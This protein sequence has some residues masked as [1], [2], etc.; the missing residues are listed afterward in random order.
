MI[1]RD[2]K[3]ENVLL[4]DDGRVKVADF[5]LARAINAETQ[6]T[7][8]GGV[9]IGTVSYLSPEL[10][11]D[12]KADARSDVYAAGV[13]LYE[14]LTGRKPHEGDVADPGRLQARARGR[15][16]AVAAGARHPAVRRRAGRPRHRPRPRRCARPTRGCCCTR[17]AG[18]AHAL[19]H[20][21][22]RRPGADRRPDPDRA[23]CSALAR[24]H[25]LRRDEPTHG[26]PTILDPGAGRP[27]RRAGPATDDTSV[28]GA[29]PAPAA[30]PPAGRARGAP[31]RRP[32]APLAARAGAAGRWCCCS[33]SRAGV[34]GWWFGVGRYTTTPGVHQPDRGRGA[35]AKVAG[36]RAGV[37]RSADRAYS[38]TVPT[39]SVVS[40]DPARRRATSLRDGTVGAVVSRGP[41]RHEVPAAARQD[42][43]RRP[44]RARR[45][46][47]WPT[48]TRRTRYS[49]KVAKGVVLATDPEAGHRA[50]P[51]RRRRPRGQQGPAA[52]Q[53]PRL[54]R[55]GRRRGRARRWRS[56]ASRSTTT[57]ENSD[58]VAKGDVI[59]QTPTSG[60]L[61]KGDTVKLVVSKGP[62]LVRCRTCAGWARSRH[63]PARGGRLR[64][65]GGGRVLHRPRPRREAE[66]RL[67]RP[68][69][70]GQHHRRLPWCDLTTR[71]VT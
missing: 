7:A 66:P 33:P 25:R 38:E 57:E 61:F 8:T 28:I 27:R 32:P 64:G 26:V 6:H 44:G 40:T 5:G 21:V 55:Q 48:A 49:E 39:G 70:E 50:A 30:A 20:G 54:H 11:V 1:H 13:L 47:A 16:A 53:G 36:R 58:T 17:S 67:R 65:A 69:A 29:R 34:G 68:G 43:R 62:V 59:S 9:L 23:R 14:M 42:P 10:V 45:T 3:P 15:P 31:G 51:R 63:H 60:R 12:G 71:G 56:S 22:A 37:P 2:V 18:C 19:D 24:R 46:P 41:E 35:E 4:A 52:D